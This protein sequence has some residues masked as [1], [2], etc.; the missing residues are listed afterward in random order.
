MDEGETKAAQ[1]R[2]KRFVSPEFVPLL[3]TF[4]RSS[5]FSR[6]HP[7]TLR[8]LTGALHQT[9][10]WKRHKPGLNDSFQIAPMKTGE[11]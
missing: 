3:A 9:G 5:Q 4:C 10:C 6:Q 7:A 8:A 1:T 11:E 2:P